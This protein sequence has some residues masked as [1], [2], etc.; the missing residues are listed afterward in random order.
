MTRAASC[1]L[2]STLGN[3]F[4]VPEAEVVANT[5]KGKQ[6]MNVAMPVEARLCLQVP[7]DAD[8]LAVIGLNKK[9]LVFP[10]RD[11]AKP[12]SKVPELTRG[13]GVRLQKYRQGDLVEESGI[14]RR[15]G[16]PHG[17]WAELD[18]YGRADIHQERGGTRGLD[19]CACICRSQCPKGFPRSGRFEG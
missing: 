11:D 19:R 3:G 15:Q 18:R 10:F 17:R 7:D 12:D 2:A 13:K 6:V 16:I 9:L 1:S 14:A 5:R 4:I 8:H